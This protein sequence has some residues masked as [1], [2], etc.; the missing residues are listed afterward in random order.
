MLKSG[1]NY[2]QNIRLKKLRKTNIQKYMPDG[3]SMMKKKLNYALKKKGMK[4]SREV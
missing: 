3:T 1:M 2:M 4:I